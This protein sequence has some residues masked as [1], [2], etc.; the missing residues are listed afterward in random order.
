MLSLEL[1]KWTNHTIASKGGRC[2]GINGGIPQDIAYPPSVSEHD[3]TCPLGGTPH[4]I[5]GGQCTGTVYGG[6]VNI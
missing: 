4:G 3:V 5:N 2:C 6:G 1:H